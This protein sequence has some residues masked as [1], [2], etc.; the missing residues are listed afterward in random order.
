MKQRGAAVV[1]ALGDARARTALDPILRELEAI[2]SL[3]VALE[4]TEKIQLQRFLGSEHTDP[5]DSFLTTRQIAVAAYRLAGGTSAQEG[6]HSLGLAVSKTKRG[7][8]HLVVHSHQATHQCSFRLPFD[9]IEASQYLRSLVL[10]TLEREFGLFNAAESEQQRSSIWLH[11]QAQ[12]QWQQLVRGETSVVGDCPEKPVLFPG[13]FHPLHQG[14]RRMVALASARLHQGVHLEISVTNADKPELDFLTIGQRVREAEAFA[15]VVLTQAPRFVDKARLFPG[16][17]FLIGADTAVRLNHVRFYDDSL[18]KRDAAIATIADQGCRFLV[19]GR[20][21]EEAFF[22]ESELALTR[23][24]RE[25]C[26][27]VTV[28]EFRV[29]ISSRELRREADGDR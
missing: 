5:E 1:V 2:N 12:P 19:F 24:L 9:V 18:R 27:F 16:A 23:R 14:H 3:L 11:Q 17:T 8:G 7:R 6:S 13:S 25:L 26:E 22:G 20:L 21:M 29:D 10:D 28:D 4:L 15:P